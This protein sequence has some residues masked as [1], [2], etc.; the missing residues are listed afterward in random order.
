ME[1]AP[2][3]TGLSELIPE[4]I[5]IHVKTTYNNQQK[6]HSKLEEQ[7]QQQTKILHVTKIRKQIK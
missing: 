7:H 6:K 3:D 4:G 5:N 1:F 2:T